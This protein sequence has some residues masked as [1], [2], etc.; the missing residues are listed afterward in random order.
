MAAVLDAVRPW[1]FVGNGESALDWR[2][3]HGRGITRFLRVGGPP[4]P[5]NRLRPGDGPDG[6]ART[7]SVEDVES[8]DIDDDEDA[9]LLSILG[10]C[11]AFIG[12]SKP[13]CGGEGPAA[14]GGRPGKVLVYCSAGVSRS[15]AVVASYL[16]SDEGASLNAA[17]AT[18][19]EHA[20]PNDN[21]LAQLSILERMGGRLDAD[22]K[23]FRAFRQNRI[24]RR[25]MLYGYFDGDGV[26]DADYGEVGARE[27]AGGADAGGTAGACAGAADTVFR[28]RT[29]RRVVATSSNLVEHEA[30]G[31]AG[32]PC[33]LYTEALSWM[34]GELE[35]GKLEGKLLCVGCGARI[36]KYS[37]RG[38]Q[39]VCKAWVVPAF[40]I[41]RAKVD[42]IRSVPDAVVAAPVRGAA[43]A[44]GA[45]RG[46]VAPFGPG[47]A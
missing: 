25:A 31:G 9:D 46:T 15:Q 33:H 40:M 32:P 21:F 38:M 37:W 6:P 29:C 2:L 23:V 35:Q 11:H 27:G 26:G 41:Q 7:S 10:R 14:A 36:G 44:A 4:P 22:S 8:I 5:M 34:R 19:P 18:L 24:A 43:A 1:L 42:A 47:G 16:M 20:S 13:D 17:L 3:C 12:R 39:C 45:R 28:C 30:A